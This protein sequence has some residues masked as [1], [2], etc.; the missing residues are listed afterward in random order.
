MTLSDG[1]KAICAQIAG[2]IIKEVIAEH[3]ESCPHG[4]KLQVSKAYI[5]G[6][7]LGSGIVSGGVGAAV[8]KVFSMVLV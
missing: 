2:E 4:I 3:I 1:D 5:V 8:F 7:V 6:I